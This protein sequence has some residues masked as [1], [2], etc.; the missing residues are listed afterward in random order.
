MR[1]FFL[2]LPWL[3]LFTLIQLGIETSALTAIFYVLATLVL[4][5]AILRRQG[6]Q[7]FQQL[8]EAQQGAVLGPRLLVDDMAMGLAGILIAVPGILTDI[9]ALVVMIGPLRR[10]VARFFG[11]PE[12]EP[13]RPQYDQSAD[14]VIEGQFRRVDDDMRP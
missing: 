12:P 4:G 13:Y 11:A 8:R 3:E 14:S 6:M 1:L 9:A 10:R 2:L 7:L 5:M